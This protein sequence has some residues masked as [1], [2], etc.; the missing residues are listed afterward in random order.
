MVWQKNPASIV[1]F[2]GVSGGSYYRQQ[3]WNHRRSNLL[4]YE[5]QQSYPHRITPDILSH[6]GLGLQPRQHTPTAYPD[7]STSTESPTA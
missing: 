2:R 4:L 5:E 7:S 6:I 1:G 3:P